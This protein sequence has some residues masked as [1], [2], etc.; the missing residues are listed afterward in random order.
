MRA[1]TRRNAGSRGE[2]VIRPPTS[3]GGDPTRTDYVTTT[4]GL[5]RA[6]LRGAGRHT[7]PPGMDEGLTRDEDTALRCLASIAED[8][9]LSEE[10]AKLMTSL[11]S[12]DRRATI[13]REGAKIPQPRSSSDSPSE[14]RRP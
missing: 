7:D 5:T 12:R 11:R 4:R 9:A 8:G 13:R 6:D 2:T 14:T 3:A 10:H 1:G